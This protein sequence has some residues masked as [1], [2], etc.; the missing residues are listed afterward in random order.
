MSDG[1][2]HTTYYVKLYSLLFSKESVRRVPNL[3]TAIVSIIH[4]ESNELVNCESNQNQTVNRNI[5]HRLCPTIFSPMI[6]KYLHRL[7]SCRIVNHKTLT[8]ILHQLYS[9]RIVNRKILIIMFKTKKNCCLQFLS[10]YTQRGK[11]AFR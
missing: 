2:F 5:Y 3:S 10:E 11:K 9:Y 8:I 7:Y 4:C 1:Y 6:V